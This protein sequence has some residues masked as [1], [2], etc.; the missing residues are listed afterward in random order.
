MLIFDSYIIFYSVVTGLPATTTAP[1]P[2]QKWV[3]DKQ[4]AGGAYIPCEWQL[5]LKAESFLQE[6]VSLIQR[7]LSNID[8]E[9]LTEVE[10][11]W[12]FAT[13]R[14]AGGHVL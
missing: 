11:C 12:H 2:S 9:G 13:F 10:V 1:P 14:F 6:T 7:N 4:V 5:T 8:E 3:R